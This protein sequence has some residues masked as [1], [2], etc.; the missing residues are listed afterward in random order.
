LSF[1]K[2]EVSIV[3]LVHLDRGRHPPR[4]VLV[5]TDVAETPLGDRP[6]GSVPVHL[7]CED[8]AYSLD[9]E[10]VDRMLEDRA[11]TGLQD[12]VEVG[13]HVL[14]D[15]GDVRVET[16]LEAHVAALGRQ[17]DEKGRIRSR[18]LC[19]DFVLVCPDV[20]E[21]P[22]NFFAIHHRS[23]DVEDANLYVTH[24]NT[25]LVYERFLGLF[26]LFN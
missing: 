13:H 2:S 4:D 14:A 17:S 8:P 20:V 18:F 6:A 19:W 10:V 22:L 7:C 24:L 26:L 12:V 9:R 25:S 16:R 5:E 11:V 15:L 1:A 3:C 21:P 23:A